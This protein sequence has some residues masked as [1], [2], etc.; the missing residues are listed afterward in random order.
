M[1]MYISEAIS[2]SSDILCKINRLVVCIRKKRG[3][4]H[5]IILCILIQRKVLRNFKKRQIKRQ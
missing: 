1:G 2:K 4:I 5:D 3:W